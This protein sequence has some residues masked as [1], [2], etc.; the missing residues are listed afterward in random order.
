MK[1]LENLY[2]RVLNSSKNNLKEE[3]R[4]LFIVPEYQYSPSEVI[5]PDFTRISEKTSLRI[6]S[7]SKFFNVK[8]PVNIGRKH[9]II[10][11]KLLIFSK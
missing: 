3:S 7:N 2:I 10:N 6:R 11:R 5:S 1:D 4:I 8:I 9:N